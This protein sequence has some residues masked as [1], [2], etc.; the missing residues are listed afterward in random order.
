L[1]GGPEKRR[2]GETLTEKRRNG[3]TEKPGNYEVPNKEIPCNYEAPNKVIPC[4]TPLVSRESFHENLL[5]RMNKKLKIIP[6]AGR[7]LGIR[8]KRAKNCGLTAEEIKENIRIRDMV[9][10]NEREM[11]KMLHKKP[12][13]CVKRRLRI[14]YDDRPPRKII[15]DDPPEDL[16][17]IKKK[18][19]I[20][21]DDYDDEPSTMIPKKIKKRIICDDNDEIEDDDSAEVLNILI[22]TYD[23][24]MANNRF[25]DK[26]IDFEYGDY[27]IQITKTK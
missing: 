24:L 22:E 16:P 19:K 15:Y 5:R 25:N 7:E 23:N 3:E 27:L 26:C 1:D 21:H 11:K 9:L 13:K 6:K 20:L 2:N 4:N 17:I 14:L 8:L 12:K 18:K 10:K